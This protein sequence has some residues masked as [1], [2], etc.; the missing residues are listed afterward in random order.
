[1][2]VPVVPK[3]DSIPH[4]CILNHSQKAGSILSVLKWYG[5]VYLLAFVQQGQAARTSPIAGGY[6]VPSAGMEENCP[7]E[8]LL[9]LSGLF[10]A[11]ST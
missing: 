4:V 10:C 9:S 5:E 3:S 2:L 8:V 11:E 7:L 6:F 1:M